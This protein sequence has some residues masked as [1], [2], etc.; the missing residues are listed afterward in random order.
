MITAD[1]LRRISRRQRLSAGMVEKDYAISWFLKENYE[2]DLLKEAIIFKGGTALKKI[3]FPETWRLSHDLDFTALGNLNPEE[4]A[5]GFKQVFSVAKLNSGIVFSL[6]SFHI[7]GGSIIA[8][9]QF[10]GPLVQKNRIRTDITR[11]EKLI[12]D[13][14]WRLVKT[15]YPDLPEFKVKVYSLKEILIEKLRSIIQRGKSRDYYDVWLL[16]KENQFDMKEM[17]DLLI[18]KCQINE[19]DYKSEL[20]FNDKRLRAAKR[21]WERAL[22][23]LTKE[24]PKFDNVVS[25]LKKKLTL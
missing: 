14:E 19:I 15:I 9:L 16:L 4:I 20:I 12:L 11:S 21:Y 8:S 23:E 25:E 24:L 17:R 18:K 5:D 13:P 2:N 22:S 1:A 7:T 10:K 6:K 3:Y